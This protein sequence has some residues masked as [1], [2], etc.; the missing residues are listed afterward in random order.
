MFPIVS[1]YYICSI[2][3]HSMTFAVHGSTNDEA[4]LPSAYAYMSVSLNRNQRGKKM[5]CVAVSIVLPDFTVRCTV[6]NCAKRNLS[7]ISLAWPLVSPP[8]S[9]DPHAIKLPSFLMAAKAP[10]LLQSCTTSWSLSRTWLL[11]P[12]VHEAPGSH[13]FCVCS[14]HGIVE[15]S[16]K[17]ATSNKSHDNFRKF[18]PLLKRWELGH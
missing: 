12:P 16:Q 6:Y 10:S 2:T 18:F 15:A 7:S 11:S 13:M 3:L 14:C 5:R 1:S 17:V 8:A 4:S 9:G